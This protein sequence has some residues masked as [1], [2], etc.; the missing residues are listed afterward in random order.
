MHASVAAAVAA[1][2][3]RCVNDDGSAGSSGGWIEAD[4]PAFKFEISV[5]RMQRR[6]E[7]KI[8]IRCCRIE[9]NNRILGT[10]TGSD[11]QDGEG[12]GQDTKKLSVGKL[13]CGHR[14][15]HKS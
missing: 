13:N 2:S 7:R 10:Q 3:A 8:N 15:V 14:G 11:G 6:A 4:R 9:I 5:D 1:F 12:Q